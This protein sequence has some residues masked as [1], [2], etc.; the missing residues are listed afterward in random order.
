VRNTSYAVDAFKSKLISNG[1][2]KL[3]FINSTLD[4][5]Q[6]FIP[7]S[8]ARSNETVHLSIYWNNSTWKTR[9]VTARVWK[10]SALVRFGAQ[11]RSP[12]RDIPVNQGSGATES[13]LF[14]NIALPS[15]APRG[16]GGCAS[17]ISACASY[18]TA[19][20]LRKLTFSQ[21]IRASERTSM[22]F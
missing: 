11:H 21:L 14:E 10:K 3:I 2:F 9:A 15:G 18:S 7:Q 17:L 6:R 5:L 12:M 20:T 8:F 1:S 19:R 13:E 22:R 16:I 4:F